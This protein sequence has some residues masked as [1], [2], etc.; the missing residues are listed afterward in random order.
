MN[1]YVVVCNY[2]NES[3]MYIAQELKNNV[4]KFQNLINFVKEILLEVDFIEKM[5]NN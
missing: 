2:F 3:Y 5:K 4:V 1:I